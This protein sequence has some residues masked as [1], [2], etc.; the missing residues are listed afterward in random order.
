LFWEGGREI[1]S[2]THDKRKTS[3]KCQIN[4]KLNDFKDIL[5][6]KATNNLYGNSYIGKQKKLIGETPQM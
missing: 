4:A 2:Q 1:V 5:R 6:A 3:R